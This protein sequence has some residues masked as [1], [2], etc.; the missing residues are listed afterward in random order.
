MAMWN[1]SAAAVTESRSVC[2]HF[3]IAK[4]NERGEYS[5]PEYSWNF[6]PF[7]TNRYRTKEYYFAGYDTAPNEDLSAAVVKMRRDKGTVEQRLQSFVHQR[8]ANC[9]SEAERKEKLVPL[10]QS[11]Y[12]EA[13]QIATTPTEKR[14]VESAKARRIEAEVGYKAYEQ[15]IMKQGRS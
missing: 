13:Q 4:T 3:A 15:I 12:E 6:W 5:L 11:Q 14:L 8:Y 2:Y 9:T 1:A 10:F 7:Y